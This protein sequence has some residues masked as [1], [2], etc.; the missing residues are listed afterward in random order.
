MFIC[1]KLYC[2]S[3][4]F[5]KWPLTGRDKTVES[6]AVVTRF[7][8]PYIVRT[9]LEKMK[10]HK[11][12]FTAAR[13]ANAGPP[14]HRNTGLRHSVSLDIAGHSWL[15]QKISTGHSWT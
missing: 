8:T 6:C 3:E 10:I 13:R 5:K 2:F 14:K 11:P 4:A 12:A 15:L 7:V 1:A 9:H